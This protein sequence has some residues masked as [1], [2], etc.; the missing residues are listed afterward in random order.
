[1]CE[2]FKRN[3]VIISFYKSALGTIHKEKI[4]FLIK[5]YT[6]HLSQAKEFTSQL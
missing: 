4:S 1:M 2:Y 5:E 6:E 3:Q